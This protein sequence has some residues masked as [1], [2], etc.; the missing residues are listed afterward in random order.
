M[1]HKIKEKYKQHRLRR[2]Q[3]RE[4]RKRQTE[5]VRNMPSAYDDAVF[6]WVAPEAIMHERGP[7]WKILMSLAVLSVI[8]WG[9]YSGAW[10]FSLVI[11]VFALAYYLIHLE[12]PKAIEIKISDMGIKLGYRKFAYSQIKAFWILYDPPYVQTLNIRVHGR[13]IEDITIFLYVD[14]PAPIREYLMSKI[15]ELEG[16]S[17]KLSD[18]LLRLF[19]I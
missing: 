15:P 9:I 19:K 1:L 8:A 6:S 4:E 16:Q 12:H 18:V 3:K 13:V 2:A 14:N 11:G 17:E 10:T 7:V 5:F